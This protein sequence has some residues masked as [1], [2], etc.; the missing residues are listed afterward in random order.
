M[1]VSRFGRTTRSSK[2]NLTVLDQVILFKGEQDAGCRQSGRDE[3]GCRVRELFLICPRELVCVLQDVSQ[4][5][6]FEWLLQVFVSSEGRG[7]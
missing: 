7:A 5:G 1:S 4:G 2:P 3:Q 6:L